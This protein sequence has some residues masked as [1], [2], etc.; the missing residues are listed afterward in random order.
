MSQMIMKHDVRN[1]LS[2][3]MDNSRDKATRRMNNTCG[4]KIANIAFTLRQGSQP[5]TSRW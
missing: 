4:A 3:D 1:L 2:C 5:A